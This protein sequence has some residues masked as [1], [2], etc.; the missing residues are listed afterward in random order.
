M[1]DRDDI[2]RDPSP[3]RGFVR[4][5]LPIVVIVGVLIG[6]AVLLWRMAHEQAT[7]VD[8]AESP[9]HHRDRHDR[10]GASGDRRDDRDR[11]A[12]LRRVLREQ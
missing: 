6:V 7:A 2:F 1:T 5:A 12:E 10:L 9:A 8:S 4:S 3:V 11:D